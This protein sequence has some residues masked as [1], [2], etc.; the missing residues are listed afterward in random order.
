ML[1]PLLSC[2]VFGEVNKQSLVGDTSVENLVPCGCAL[3]TRWFNGV[4]AAESVVTCRLQDSS[5]RSSLAETPTTYVPIHTRLFGRET[6]SIVPV[7][8]TP[9]LPTYLSC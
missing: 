5:A 1:L 7:A 6:S 4:C 2:F 8:L 9:Y 3:Q